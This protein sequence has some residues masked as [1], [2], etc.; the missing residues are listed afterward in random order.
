MFANIFEINKKAVIST[1]KTMVSI[2]KFGHKEVSF[3]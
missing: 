3:I 2:D 1:Q